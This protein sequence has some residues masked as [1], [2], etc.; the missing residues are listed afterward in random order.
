MSKLAKPMP[1]GVENFRELCRKY[2]FVDKTRFIKELID[3][4]SVITLITR[5][6]R[7]GK[8]LTLSMLKYFFTRDKAEENRRLFAGLDIEKADSA[9]MREQGT[10]P[11]VSLTLKDAARRNYTDAID[12]LSRIM[13]L[14]YNEHAYLLSA[15]TL[16]P[17]QREH[18]QSILS[19]QGTDGD[20]VASLKYLML[21]LTDYWH[22]SPILLLDEYDAPILS[23]WEHNYYPECMDFMRTF[24]TMA[25][26]SND[27]L[28]FA[29]VTGVTR[30]SKESIFSG[31]N[32]LK[33]RSVLSN[34]YSDIFG[35]TAQETEQLM[36]DA[37]VSDKLPELRRWYDGYKF[38]ATEIYNPWSVIQFIDNDCEFQPYWLNTSSNA[39]LKDMLRYID[40]ERQ[41]ELSALLQGGSVETIVQENTV[42]ADLANSRDA[43]YMMLLTT[44]YLKAVNVY[45]GDDDISVAELK[46]PNEEIS[47]AYKSEIYR[48]VVP[49]KGSLLLKNMLKAMI[50]GNAV[51]F[52][53][54]LTAILKDYVSFHDTAHN[55]ECFYHGL[56]LG[57]S[58]LLEGEYHLSSNREAGYGRFDLALFP[59]NKDY[60]GVIME[61]KTAKDA[62]ELD[63]LAGDALTQIKQKEYAATLA[64]LGVKQIWPY[65]IA[66]CGKQAAIK[67]DV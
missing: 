57:L 49:R 10:R 5:P 11:V 18:F 24:L 66:F 67:S 41:R 51:E 60:A 58:V 23:A 7:F 20:I 21:Y 19:H 44:G 54:K 35:F 59:R 64:N 17:W 48:Y 26:K 25:L 34:Q 4:Q 32:N 37:G 53:A 29:V 8:T 45:K 36:F 3:S 39:I 61:F 33:V 9:Y 22:R 27:Y 31:L 15:D 2:Y 40:A 52:A 47:R 62:E 56:M 13:Q 14:V 46:I 63:N 50:S 55:P 1:I 12:M 65:G 42:Y 28:D 38:G 30:V 16:S 6:R 43:L